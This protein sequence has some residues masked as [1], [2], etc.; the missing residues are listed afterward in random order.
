MSSIQ[1]LLRAVRKASGYA[2]F[3]EWEAATDYGDDNPNKPFKPQS[4]PFKAVGGPTG[5]I[6]E[7][8]A[9]N[10]D[11]G[12]TDW[13]GTL[14]NAKVGMTIDFYI[15]KIGDEL[16]TNIEVWI[17]SETEIYWSEVGGKVHFISLPVSK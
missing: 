8:L 12:M 2:H 1:K 9:D 13:E 17:K 15:T 14:K 6:Y 16:V 7:D 3:H 5:K 10:W 11:G 4:F